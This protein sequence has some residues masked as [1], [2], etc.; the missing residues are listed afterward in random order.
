MISLSILIISIEFH[1]FRLGSYETSYE[2]YDLG[3]RTNKSKDEFLRISQEL[4]EYLKSNRTN[5][6]LGG[7]F[8]EKEV[9][10][11]EDVQD[12]FTG[13]R[14]LKYI[15]IVLSA[16]LVLY[17]FIAEDI[18]Y[19][20][21]K[22]YKGLFFN[23]GLLGILLLMI[24]TDFSKYFEYFHLIFFDNDL[25]LLDPKIDLLIQMMPESFFMDMSIKIGLTYIMSILFL[26]F[27]TRLIVKFKLFS[28][29]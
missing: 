29:K 8:N 13:L 2:K 17:F 25:W 28:E 22:M 26:Q 6:E 16:S 10:H 3:T 27:I 21:K 12:I 15:G 7:I 14:L 18:N 4:I 5:K 24:V 23:F 20:L 9:M 1:T 19:L 11:M